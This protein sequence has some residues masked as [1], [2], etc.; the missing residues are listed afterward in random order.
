MIFVYCP[1]C[2]ESIV[3]PIG[4]PGAIE[5][6]I[7]PEC[8]CTIFLHHS[9]WRPHVYTEDQ[10]AVNEADKTIDVVDPEARAELELDYKELAAILCELQPALAAREVKQPERSAG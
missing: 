9:R 8:G 4:K 3:V 2:D 7:C 5:K 10:V 6:M 1:H